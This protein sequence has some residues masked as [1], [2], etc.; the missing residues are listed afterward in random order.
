[1]MATKAPRSSVILTSYA[2]DGRAIRRIVVSYEQY[3]DGEN[4]VVD[5]NNYR[6]QHG[7]RRLTGEVYDSKRHLQQSFDIIY[8]EEGKHIKGRAVHDDGTIIED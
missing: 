5:S 6:S 1:M 4:P 3:Y 8:D 7:V 2:A